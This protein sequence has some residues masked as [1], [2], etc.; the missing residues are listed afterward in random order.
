MLE[1][2]DLAGHRGTTALF[3]NLSFRVAAGSAL[4]V[5]GPNGTGKTTLLRIVAGLTAP[6]AGQMRWKGAPLAAFA[7][8]LRRDVLFAGHTVALKDELTAEEN[9]RSL[10][11][12]AGGEASADEVSSALDEVSLARQ[13]SLP[14]RVLSAGQRRRVGL[15]RLRLLRRTLWVLDEPLTALDASGGEL[16]AGFV[17]T[18]LDR[19]GVVV[20]A[21]HQPLGVDEHRAQSLT[22]G[23]IR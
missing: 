9:V 13:R 3:R 18:H 2:H 20:A 16:L 14:A 4:I 11:A 7:P 19:G 23:E 1:A 10:V 6:S 5:Q 15:A 21:T 12:L 22:L 17:R 8:E